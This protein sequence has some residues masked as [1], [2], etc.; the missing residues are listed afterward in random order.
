MVR[1]TKNSTIG[2]VA[3]AFLAI[4]G[5]L[6]IS[7]HSRTKEPNTQPK[8]AYIVEELKG[9]LDVRLDEI[10]DTTRVNACFMVLVRNQELVG[11]K[12]S[13]TQ[14]EARFNRRYNYPYVMLND[15]PFTAE[16]KHEVQSMTSAKVE[17]G[18][19]PKAHWSYP[20]HIN[21]KKA[22]ELREKNKDAYLYGGSE[23]YRHMCRFYSGFFFRHNL[24]LKYDYY[25]RVEPDV[26]FTCDIDFDPFQRLK[27][28]GAKYGFTMSLYEF[29]STVESLWS[30][31]KSWLRTS[32]WG[33]KLP[34]N[35]SLEFISNNFGAT[36]NM[37]HFWSNFEIASFDL[38]RS[39][40][41][42]DYFDYLDKSGGFFYERWGDAPVHSI[43]ASLT[44]PRSQMMFF[45][46]IGYVHDGLAHCP[47][48]PALARKCHCDPG[49]DHDSGSD[50]CIPRWRSLGAR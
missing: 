1:L 25:W 50:S 18:L 28:N 45:E 27:D 5:I 42:L 30:T 4:L 37:C 46:D 32:G 22:A 19:I 39:K 24:T 11:L 44:L 16:F 47:Q 34:Q 38:W 10:A 17:F 12:S 36:F 23:S 15:V 21:Q 7:H 29:S 2:V 49:N 31:T 3:T 8:V 43:F 35:N 26:Q 40:T 14:L 20:S 13:M 48:S 9:S 41:Y 6:Y 33:S